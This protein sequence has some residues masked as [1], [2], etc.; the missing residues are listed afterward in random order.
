MSTG[1]GARCL[2][3]SV[4]YAANVRG[5]LWDAKGQPVCKSEVTLV[6]DRRAPPSSRAASRGMSW[7][8]GGCTG[9][10]A[11]LSARPA[12]GARGAR[13]RRPGP[14]SWQGALVPSRVALPP[15]ALPSPQSEPPAPSLAPRRVQFSAAGPSGVCSSERD[16]GCSR[17]KLPCR[18]CVLFT[19]FRRC[20]AFVRIRHDCPP[21]QAHS[22]LNTSHLEASW[23]EAAPG[24]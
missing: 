9:R 13:G 8:C 10:A 5:H 4:I 12:G 17:W 11:W 20:V 7:S 1:N 19:P 3:V 22:R 18:L 14:S 15:V 6:G 21:E 24:P 2:L 23:G 16:V